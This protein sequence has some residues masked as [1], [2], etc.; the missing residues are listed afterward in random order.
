MASR[1]VFP[2]AAVLLFS[3]Q[4]AWSAQPVTGP[5]VED[6]L[7]DGGHVQDIWLSIEPDSWRRLLANFTDKK[8]TYRC[9]FTWRGVSLR[10]VGIHTRG[11]GS[12]NGIKPGLALEFSK[13]ND[14]Q[15][16]GRLQAVY[17]RN[18]SQDP[19]AM[20]E[21]ITMQVFAKM[22]LPYQRT[23]HAKLFV[24]GQYFGLFELIEP[25]DS[26]FL[27]S[28]FGEQDGDLFEGL[29]AK[30]YHFEDLGDSPSL[31]VPRFF[32]PKNHVGDPIAAARL[33]AMIHTIN[34][35]SDAEFESA[36]EPYLDLKAFLTHLAVETA[37]A[38]ADGILSP[39]GMANYY[40]YRRA[41]DNRFTFVV[42]DKEM[43][44]NW[45]TFSIWH[46]AGQNVLVRRA[47]RVPELRQHYLDAVAAVGE[48]LG[49]EDGWL[50]Q[51]IEAEYR[52]IGP[53]MREDP[54]LVVLD[55]GF[56]V[57]ATPELFEAHVDWLRHF[58]LTRRDSLV[59]QLSEAGWTAPSQ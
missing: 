7:F 59:E 33:T 13:F 46:N 34:R 9:D 56:F 4:I 41:S 1:P 37:V 20:H 25:L 48:I 8:T 19:S 57:R 47:F 53:A 26:A 12:L 51:M 35:A 58:A 24:N 52:K 6:L 5:A 44:F 23:S 45:P 38:E 22:G 21:R 43:T 27:E 17:L 29:G 10:D 16:L 18:F 11:S 36:L 50:R 49:G 39:T 2:V 32:E 30:D 28:R 31:Y 15:R 54:N 3:S 14:S 40:L 42:W 55:N